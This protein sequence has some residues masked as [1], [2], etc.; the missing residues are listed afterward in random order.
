MDLDA[1]PVRCFI[2][3]AELSSFSRAA[4]QMNVSQ[5]ALSATIKELERRLGFVLFDRSSRAVNLT[6]E[7]KL[8]LGNAYRYVRESEIL[9]QASHD[10]R[11]TDLRIS[12]AFHTSLIDERNRLLAGF[13]RENPDVNLQIINNHH[14]R[15]WAKLADG[16]VDLLLSLEPHTPGDATTP[17][18]TLDGL[19]TGVERIFLSI[20]PVTLLVPREHALAGLSRIALADLENV[21]IVVPNRFHGALTEM[22][23]FAL[24]E[25]GAKG[26]RPPEGTAVGMEWY[27]A[28]RR[29]PAVALNWF[30]TSAMADDMVSRPVDG[31]GET[32]LTL[33][34]PVV[35]MRPAA[36]RMWQFAHDWTAERGADGALGHHMPARR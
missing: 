8:F 31:L 35:A 22:L 24:V 34:K 15:G 6:A 30:G 25:A 2:A 28:L 19:H 36:D 32:A 33:V 27:G 7:G 1:R 12:A 16:E 26:V 5:P 29:L 3:V 9:R 20:R 23:R 11:S 21:E 10:I 17:R 18:S 14:G 4:R 13:L